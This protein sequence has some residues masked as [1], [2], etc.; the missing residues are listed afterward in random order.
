[1][2]I[3]IVRIEL[4]GLDQLCGRLVDLAA[5]LEQYAQL[6]MR[7]GLNRGLYRR[8]PEERLGLVHVASRA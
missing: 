5:V 3:R 6:V 1:M 2:W 8:T 4:D 7:L